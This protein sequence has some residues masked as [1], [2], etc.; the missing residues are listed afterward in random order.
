MK[1][2]DAAN[3]LVY[4]MNGSC[5]DLTNMKINKLLYYAQGHYLQKYGTRMFDDDFEAWDHGPVVA[6]VY[7]R[8][9]GMGSDPITECDETCISSV[10][11]PAADVLF[12]VAR[13]YGKYTAGA[14]R[15]MTH[16]PNGPWDQ[17]YSKGSSHTIIPFDSIKA[18]FSRPGCKELHSLELDFTDDSFVGY[19]DEDG[20]LVLPKD[21]DDEAV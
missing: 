11:D 4:L 14:L 17:V 7:S 18:W 13:E 19:R 15:S 3:Y 21:W 20:N 16:V 5:D 10:P 2:I 12:E 1:A 9:Q 8:Y 6:S